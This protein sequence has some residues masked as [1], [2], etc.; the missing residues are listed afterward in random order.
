MNV[1]FTP[2]GAC[3]A[4][5]ETDAGIDAAVRQRYAVLRA[6]MPHG[7]PLTV[8]HLGAE[9][10]AV[11]CGSGPAPDAVI[12]LALGSRKTADAHFRRALPTPGEMEEAIVTVEDEV[13]RVRALPI[14]GTALWTNDP[15]F[16]EIA[17]FAGVPDQPERVLGVDAVERAFDRL[18]SVALGRPAAREGLP[19]D[20]GFA[21]SLLILREFMHHLQFAS[22]TVRV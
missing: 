14:G 8:L 12:V 16:G 3:R 20:A 17:R 6:A 9:R 10:T 18:A 22:I 7:G 15:V 19:A 11:A 13:T 1:A 2:S 21:A 5:D 4:T